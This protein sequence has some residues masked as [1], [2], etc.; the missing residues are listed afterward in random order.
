GK[1]D[2]AVRYYLQAVAVDPNLGRAYSGL[3]AVAFNLKKREEAD[4][5]FKKALAL[6]D[7]M[8]E[9]EKYR[10]LGA[11]HIFAGNSEQAVEAFRKLTSLFPGDSAG[12]TN[13]S[14]A[15]VRLGKMQESIEPSR[16]AVEI[17]PS[18]LL[19]RYNYAIHSMF[20]G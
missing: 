5:Y 10:T 15:Y 16:R 18:N 20:A 8:S 4:G 9:R 11:Y 3:A 7:R 14:T 17:T 19:R 6:I 12:Y 1:S 13:L 2:D